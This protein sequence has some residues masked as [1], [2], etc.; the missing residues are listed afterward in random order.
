MDLYGL[1]GV[2]RAASAVEIERA[3]RRLARRYHPGVNP[4]D[5]V[6]HQMYERIGHAYSVL[7]D[8]ERR[9]QYDRVGQ[10]A[11][12]PDEAPVF[13]EG[14]DFSAPAEGPVAATFSELFA[15][16]FRQAA[17]QATNPSRGVSLEATLRLSFEDAVRGGSFPLSIVRQDRC[18][19]CG[20]D[21][22]V[23]R[24]PV[25]CP[26]CGGRG[27]NR[28]VRGHMV[29]TRA[30]DGCG[31]SGRLVT[32]P[33]RP[34][35]GAGVQG[36]SEVVTVPVPPGVESGARMAVPGRGHAGAGGGQPGDLYV[37]VDVAEHPHFRRVGRDLH[38]TLPVAIHEAV[39][40]ARVDVPTLDGPVR[41]RIPPGTASG[42]R[43]RLRGR[44]VPPVA[45][46]AAE[47]G[48]LIVELQI[49]LPPVRDERSR[50]L[51][52]EFGRLNDTDVRAGLFR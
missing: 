23:A 5:R 51:L 25:V 15:D 6:A 40:G 52:R 31:G 26:T 42:Q 13:F 8:P 14:F 4:G 34:C 29:F 30:C 33:C 21:G 46:V 35:G 9:Q 24:P 28:W 17:H 38:L 32:E 16:V 1:L 18:A 48:D 2:S 39:L 45:G 44:G 47:A 22:R 50:E 41:L 37:T 49:V 27:A 12:A 3:Y 11:A 43:L 19:S 36:R 10:V 7:V 20:G